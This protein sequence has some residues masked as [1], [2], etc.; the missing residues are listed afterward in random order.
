M[1]GYSGRR[2]S[3]TENGDH[4]P[5]WTSGVLLKLVARL[6]NF[7]AREDG[8]RPGDDVVCRVANRARGEIEAGLRLILGGPSGPADDEVV[9]DF[10]SLAIRRRIDVNMTWVADCGGRIV[11]ALLPIVS[12]GRTM[13]LLSPGT[14]YRQTTSQAVGVL[15]DSV[16]THFA[17][18]QTVLAQILLDPRDRTVR[19]M[20]RCRGFA[21]LAELVYLQ[22]HLSRTPE[23]P[24]L[25][26]GWFLHRY[27]P[28]THAMFAE[29]IQQS[30][31]GSMDCPALNGRRDIEDVIAGHQAAG[32]FDPSLWLV[33]SERGEGRAVL[34]LNQTLVGDGIELVYLG[35]AP[36]A[37]G[38]GIGDRLMRL[39]CFLTANRGVSDLSMAV[40]ARNAPALRLYHRHGLKRVGS[41]IA[42]V[43]ELIRSA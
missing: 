11:W 22:R 37:R 15:C 17:E 42:L 6:S 43:R 1:G 38:R 30:Y 12:P 3:G 25:A 2:E 8:R 27:S 28:S 21:D 35:V 34:L 19:E 36:Q 14:A 40:D 29:A 26:D 16:C 31:H 24:D 7:L 10:L 13:L 32:V 18:R 9:L 23:M 4:L 33:L 5:R 41:R 20:Y 39:A